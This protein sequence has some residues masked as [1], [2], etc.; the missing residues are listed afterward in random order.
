[1]EIIQKN[2]N[3]ILDLKDTLNEM[4]NAIDDINSR[5]NQTKE[6]SELADVSF[7]IIQSE[8]K[9]KNEESLHEL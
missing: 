8:E 3:E 2:Q 6:R 5:L 1:M 7:E 4:K 9:K